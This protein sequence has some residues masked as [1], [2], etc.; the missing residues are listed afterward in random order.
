MILLSSS[1]LRRKSW[2]DGCNFKG[3]ELCNPHAIYN[4]M[5]SG[6]F[7]SYW[8]Y[9][10]YIYAINHYLITKEM[11]AGRGYADIVYTFQGEILFVGINYDE[12]TKKHSCKIERFVK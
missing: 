4:A 2:Y 1:A 8:C 3:F 5:Y 9:L 6:K 10:A 12:E 11:P 7:K